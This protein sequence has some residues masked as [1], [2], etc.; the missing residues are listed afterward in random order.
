VIYLAE[1]MNTTVSIVVVNW[2]TGSMLRECRQSIENADLSGIDLR[3]VIVVDNASTDGS[4]TD[5]NFHTLPLQVNTNETNQGFGMACNQG[6]TRTTGE[7]ILFLNPDMR[8]YVD[9]LSRTLSYMTSRS[10]NDV[11]ICGVRLRKLCITPLI[12]CLK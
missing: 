5:L 6:A 2:N 8:L 1:K 3:E 11:G 7:F 12:V 10:A 4:A 9:T